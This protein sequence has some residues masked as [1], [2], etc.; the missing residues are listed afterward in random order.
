[1]VEGGTVEGGAVEGGAVEGGAVEGGAV[2]GGAEAGGVVEGGAE[3]S[4]ENCTSASDAEPSCR[5]GLDGASEGGPEGLTT[6]DSWDAG[7]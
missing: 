1:V 5:D 4:A 6:A 2:E 7:A 3:A